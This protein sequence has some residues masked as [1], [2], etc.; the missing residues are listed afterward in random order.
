MAPRATPVS[1]EITATPA[2]RLITA[3]KTL[4]GRVAG[5]LKGATTRMRSASAVIQVKKLSGRGVSSSRTCSRPV[6]SSAPA[7]ATAA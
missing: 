6:A 2:T 7:A 4:L 5:W 3:V 1:S